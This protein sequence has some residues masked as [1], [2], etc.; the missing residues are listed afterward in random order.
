MSEYTLF[1]PLYVILIFF[2]RYLKSTA[3]DRKKYNVY[4]WET[5]DRYLQLPQ[6]I[7]QGN[8]GEKKMLNCR[9]YLDKFLFHYTGVQVF[10][11]IW[12]KNFH[13]TV[14]NF[15]RFRTESM[16]REI[17]M[18][19]CTNIEGVKKGNKR[20]ILNDFK[21]LNAGLIEIRVKEDLFLW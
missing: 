9:V 2:D 21:I 15:A 16:T 6:I 1:C 13:R 5:T 12:W 20:Y 10:A 7:W 11:L 4:E 19:S 17:L 3:W 18:N 14:E 8:F